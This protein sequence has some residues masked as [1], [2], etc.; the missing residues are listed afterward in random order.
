MCPALQTSQTSKFISAAAAMR[1]YTNRT[2]H[3]T[4][5]LPRFQWKNSRSLEKINC[6]PLKYAYYPGIATAI[7]ASGSPVSVSSCH[8]SSV[9]GLSSS[10]TFRLGVEFPELPAAYL[11]AFCI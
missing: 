1:Y 4:I 11:T 2:T 10:E 6:V 8:L 3:T 7:S 9:P 5:E